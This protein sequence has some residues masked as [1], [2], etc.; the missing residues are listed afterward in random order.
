MPYCNTA[1]TLVIFHWNV[2]FIYALGSHVEPLYYLH[3]FLEKMGFPMIASTFM[4]DHHHERIWCKLREILFHSLFCTICHELRKEFWAFFLVNFIITFELTF[5]AEFLVWNFYT[6][7]VRIALLKLFLF[8]FF[9][10]YRSTQQYSPVFPT[11]TIQPGSTPIWRRW[12]RQRRNWL[13]ANNGAIWFRS[14][15]KWWWD[16]SPQYSSASR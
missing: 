12:W 4:N 9:L 15:W 1:I 11:F 10:H 7:L 13:W 5:W 14:I 2:I 16:Q 3:G 8:W 6:I